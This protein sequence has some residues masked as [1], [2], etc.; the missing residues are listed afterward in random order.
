[1]DG[2]GGGSQLK[3]EQIPESDLVYRWIPHGWWD[4]KTQKPNPNN[5]RGVDFEGVSVEWSK[6]SD[7]ERCK[8][9]STESVGVGVVQLHVGEVRQID[10]L[11][12]E[13]KPE[14]GHPEHSLILGENLGRD[15]PRIKVELVDIC[16]W[17]IHPPTK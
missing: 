16:A 1:M 12:V 8:S 10:A 9:H 3:P 5:F 2:E 13:H 14:P 15:A 7:P 17:A 4:K 6:Y 11:K